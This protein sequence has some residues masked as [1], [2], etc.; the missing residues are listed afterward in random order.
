MQRKGWWVIFALVALGC[1]DP[2]ASR[3]RRAREAGERAA[4]AQREAEEKAREAAAETEEATR[5]AREK[6]EEAEVR[7]YEANLELRRAIEKDLDGIDDRTADLLL[8]VADAKDATRRADAE[9]RLRSIQ[10]RAR[11]A[12]ERAQTFEPA[13]TTHLAEFKES[14]VKELRGLR[15]EL[16]EIDVRF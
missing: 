14:M 6:T 15:D 4:E 7:L 11:T 5:E 3:E 2:V 10:A 9:Q 1:D 12:R 13:S 8:D 16:G